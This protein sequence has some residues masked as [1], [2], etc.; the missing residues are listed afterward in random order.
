MPPVVRL[1]DI[2]TGHGCWT[3]RPNA[4][5][6]P[7][8]FVNSRGAHRQGDKWKKHCKPCGI[9]PKCHGSV[10]AKGS[11]TVYVN[12]RQLGRIGDPIACTSLCATGS[13]NVRAGG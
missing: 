2:C 3:P 9:S 13:P 11:S 5:A 8:V 4:S 6:S 7:N 12:S 1:R 10:L